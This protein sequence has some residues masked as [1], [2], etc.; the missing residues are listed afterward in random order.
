MF[1]TCIPVFGPDQSDC[2]PTVLIHVLTAGP[3]EE[4]WQAAWD[5]QLR[6]PFLITF[7]WGSN[8]VVDQQSPWEWHH[9]C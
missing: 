1:K 3:E 9:C 4:W 6:S 5:L 8:S 7:P 2:R